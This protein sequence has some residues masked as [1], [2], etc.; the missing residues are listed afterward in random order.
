MLTTQ[1][2]A[3]PYDYGAFTILWLALSG[4]AAS[5]PNA[6]SPLLLFLPTLG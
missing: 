1:T 5:A 2:D 3:M 4:P 6:V